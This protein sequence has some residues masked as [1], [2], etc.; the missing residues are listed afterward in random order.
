MGVEL[1]EAIE[2]LQGKGPDDLMDVT[3]DLCAHMLL[4]TNKADN[5]DAALQQLRA[6][7][8]SGELRRAW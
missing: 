1:E 3:L 7:L 6:K 4:L 2:A 8:D 5:E